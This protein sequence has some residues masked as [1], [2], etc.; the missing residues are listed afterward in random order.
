MPYL[1]KA[2]L[3]NFMNV[4]IALQF[5]V[6]SILEHGMYL[7]Q[8]PK[9]FGH[10]LEPGTADTTTNFHC[11]KLVRLLCCSQ[12]LEQKPSA[13]Q[14]IFDNLLFRQKTKTTTN[15]KHISGEQILGPAACSVFQREM[16]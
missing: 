11:T 5:V 15:Q 10:F 4:E 12:Y 1:H 16:A 2:S 9:T 3:A 14:N 7:H 6:K 8:N 13:R